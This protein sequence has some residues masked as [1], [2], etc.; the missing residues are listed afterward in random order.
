MSCGCV[1]RYVAISFSPN[2]L[3]FGSS[4]AYASWIITLGGISVLPLLAVFL[5]F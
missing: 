1:L 5:K 2:P 3:R 4:V